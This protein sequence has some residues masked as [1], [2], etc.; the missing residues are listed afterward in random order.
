MR[1]V[2]RLP[3]RPNGRNNGIGAKFC[4]FEQG[5]PLTPMEPRELRPLWKQ[6]SLLWAPA[7]AKFFR[8]PPQLAHPSKQGS[9]NKTTM[10]VA[11]HISLSKG[12]GV[13][14]T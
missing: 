13:G 10:A 2:R 8:A 3:E 12:M 9:S 1:R 4:Y 5:G 6:N 7:A 14:R 11:Q